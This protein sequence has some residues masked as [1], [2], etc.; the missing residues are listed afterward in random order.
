MSTITSANAVFSLVIP[1]VFNTPVILE[2]YATDDAF[3]SDAIT[4][5]EVVMGV[6]GQMSAGFVFSPI[7][8]KIKL[9]ADSNSIQ[10]FEAWNAIQQSVKDLYFANA[11]ITLI[12]P[13]A[14]YDL[15]K[16]ALTTFKSIPDA[17]KMLQSR[18]FE[19]TFESVTSAEV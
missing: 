12:G 10:I 16:G 18:D 3:S 7:K 9:Q 4:K 19:I 2:G 15:Y 8:M 6:D 17:K 11:Q 5:A 14:V 13:G 1:G